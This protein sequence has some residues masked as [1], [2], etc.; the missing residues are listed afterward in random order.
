MLINTAGM[1]SAEQR[2][3]FSGCDVIGRNATYYMYAAAAQFA[4]YLVFGLRQARRTSGGLPSR[5]RWF[6]RF[7]VPRLFSKRQSPGPGEAGDS[8]MDMSQASV[9]D[10]TGLR[11][12]G[13]NTADEL[14]ALEEGR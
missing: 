9:G 6:R 4:V 8:G 11:A 13:A 7:R 1:D 10:G 12:P 3:Y 2:D 5:P 14:S